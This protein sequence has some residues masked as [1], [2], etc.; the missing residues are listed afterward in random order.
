MPSQCHY[1]QP[2]TT[3][4]MT[5][6]DGVRTTEDGAVVR[7]LCGSDTCT[8]GTWWSRCH[9][10]VITCQSGTYEEALSAL[11]QHRQAEPAQT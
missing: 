5:T 9:C 11:E 7:C 10:G 3:A 8:S 6:H 4:I 2:D 1:D